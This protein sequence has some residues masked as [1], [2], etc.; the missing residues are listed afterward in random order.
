VS[1]AAVVVPCFNHGSYLPDAIASVQ[2][3]TLRDVELVVVNDGSDEPETLEALELVRAAGTRVIDQPNLGLAAARNRGFEETTAAYVLPLDADNAMRPEYLEVAIARLEGDPKLGVVYGDAEFFGDR[4]GR[5]TVGGFDLDRLL[6]GNFIDACAVVRRSAWQSVSGY[7]GGMPMMGFEDWDLWLSFVEA[8]WNFSYVPEQLFDYRVRQGSMAATC[9]IPENRAVLYR[10]ITHKHAGLYVP[11]L[12]SIIA[13]YELEFSA[14]SRD[15]DRLRSELA[16]VRQL[17]HQRGSELGETQARLQTT[18]ETAVV[19]QEALDKLRRSHRE[20]ERQRRGYESELQQ[21]QAEIEEL[22]R[23]RDAA[24][25]ELRALR[26]RT[27]AERVR[28]L[29]SRS[30]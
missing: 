13:G 28:G 7:D 20:L 11:R 27:L 5:W 8:G 6:R 26:Q 30:G 3:S 4:T 29:V 19:A 23:E 22:R 1:R 17:H 15:A 18:H 21:L 12:D 16:E 14:A 2:G 25:N 10:Y 24:T 9:S